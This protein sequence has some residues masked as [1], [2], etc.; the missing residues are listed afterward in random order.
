LALEQRRLVEVAEQEI[1]VRHRRLGPAAGVAD[2]PGIGAGAFW[3]HAQRARAVDPG[4]RSAAGGDLGEVD[5]RYADRMP[6]SIHPPAHAPSAAALWVWR[7]F[8]LAAADQA[9][10]RGRSAHVER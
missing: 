8:K 2:R 7:R 3:P 4:N 5:D 10:L 9:R 6:R 1:A